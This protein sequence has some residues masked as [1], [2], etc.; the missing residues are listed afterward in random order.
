MIPSFYKTELYGVEFPGFPS[1]AG[2]SSLALQFQLE[3]SQWFD[4]AKI[5]NHQFDQIRLLVNYAYRTVPFYKKLFDEHNFLPESLQNPEDITNIPLLK[6][7]E[8]QENPEQIISQEIPREH[9]HVFDVST[10]GSTG[11][12]VDVKRTVLMNQVWDGLILREH[13]WYQRDVTQE[14][15]TIKYAK[16]GEWEPPFGLIRQGWG[17]ATQLI[18]DNGLSSYLN[19]S[20]PIDVQLDWLKHR[21]PAYLFIYP[22]NLF[23]LAKRAIDRNIKIDNL[24]HI[25]TNGESL[26]D[27]LRD[28]CKRAFDVE[29][30]DIYGTL[31]VGFIAFQCP[32]QGHYHVQSENVYVEIL[33]EN[34]KPC[35]PGG[36]GRV[37]ITSL[38]NF[39][40]P[41]IRYDIGDYAS[42]GDP[43]E[44]GRGLP[45]ISKIYGRTR[46][47]LTLPNGDK[48]WPTFG[49]REY[50]KIADIK[51]FQIIQKTLT[52]LHVRLVC[53]QM[54]SDQEDSL[55]EVIR[56]AMRYDFEI[57]ITYHDNL[58]RGPSDKFEE[59]KSELL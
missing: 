2:A 3:Q 11:R 52:K 18:F 34:D 47:V 42:F 50:S 49:Y 4:S 9:G 33:D 51:Q 28:V 54:T 31:E 58:E 56:D 39:A 22:T 13:N 10:S 53:E 6:R 7:T 38:H 21:N 19:S 26:P 48:Y 24:K 8:L 15:A 27:G 20:A 46:N 30:Y 45:V 55:R 23:E 17:S 1:N 35:K 29:L 16:K 41:L 25:R 12:P 14:Y 32:E 5:I 36:I 43:C 37:V 44:C 40:T 59:F 57:D